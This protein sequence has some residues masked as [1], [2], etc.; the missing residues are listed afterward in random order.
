MCLCSGQDYLRMLRL[1]IRDLESF[2][3]NALCLLSR[4]CYQRNCHLRQV[5]QEIVEYGSLVLTTAAF[6]V[7]YLVIILS[8]ANLPSE[9]VAMTRNVIRRVLLYSCHFYIDI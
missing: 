3:H 8:Y 6:H 1:E 5:L 4:K 2:A 7:I 9:T